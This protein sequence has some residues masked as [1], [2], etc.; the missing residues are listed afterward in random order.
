MTD[1]ESAAKVYK[2]TI[3]SLVVNLEAARGKPVTLDGEPASTQE[4]RDRIYRMLEVVMK[5]GLPTD[6][7]ARINAIEQ[8]VDKSTP[9]EVS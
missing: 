4:Q 5:G 9:P 6:L 7:E 8:G 2:R 1:W 3:D